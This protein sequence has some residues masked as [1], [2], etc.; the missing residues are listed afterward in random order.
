LP[1]HIWSGT[2]ALERTPR[3]PA[4]SGIESGTEVRDVINLA[5]VNISEIHIA[6]SGVFLFKGALS[7]GPGA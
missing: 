4:N 5:S 7:N 1:T 6:P 2:G 3:R